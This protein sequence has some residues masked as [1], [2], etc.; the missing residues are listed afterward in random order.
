MAMRPIQDIWNDGYNHG[1]TLGLCTGSILTTTGFLI[2]CI[3]VGP[4]PRS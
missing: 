4:N 2:G 3:I 1:Y